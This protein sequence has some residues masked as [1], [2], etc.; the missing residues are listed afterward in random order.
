MVGGTSGRD[1]FKEKKVYIVSFSSE[2]KMG[3]S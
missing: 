2:A 3:F 1:Y